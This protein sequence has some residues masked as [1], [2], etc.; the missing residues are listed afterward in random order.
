[1]PCD[2]FPA[3]TTAEFAERFMSTCKAPDECRRIY[4]KHL[5]LL[6]CSSQLVFQINSYQ[7]RF[8]RKFARVNDGAANDTFRK[9][10]K[11]IDEMYTSG[12][13]S[14]DE[15]EVIL[16]EDEQC[17]YGATATRESEFVGMNE[18]PL[19][20]EVLYTEATGSPILN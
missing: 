7:L 3:L 18:T 12:A 6:V 19:Y 4:I 9:F 20:E 1:M 10:R 16:Q 11:W 13:P 8:Q 2:K 5:A 17:I 14:N 15:W